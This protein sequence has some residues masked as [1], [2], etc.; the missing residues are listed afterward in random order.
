MAEGITLY[1]DGAPGTPRMPL[2]GLRAI[3][4]NGLKLTIDGKRRQVSLET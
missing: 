3:T 4:T 2:L 1:P